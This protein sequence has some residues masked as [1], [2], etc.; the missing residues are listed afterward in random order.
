MPDRKVAVEGWAE[1][2]EM[3][4]FDLTS[5]FEDAG[6]AAIIYTAS[7]RDGVLQVESE[8]TLRLARAV[9]IPVI[10][11]GGLASIED[12]RGLLKPSTRCSKARSR[13][14]RSTT[15]AIDLARGAGADCARRENGPRRLSRIRTA[16]ASAAS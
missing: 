7:A 3:T 6:V 1:T 13:A 12:V 16:S 9:S 2:S 8:A 4:E 14:G 5:Q 10:A 15:A 11:S